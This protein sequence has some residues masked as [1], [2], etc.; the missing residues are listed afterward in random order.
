MEVDEEK[1][2][3]YQSVQNPAS[4]DVVVEVEEA[5]PQPSQHDEK[6][7]S[8][9]LQETSEPPVVQ[10]TQASWQAFAKKESAG[11]EASNDFQVSI[12]Y[13]GSHNIRD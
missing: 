5:K 7:Q 12:Q 3:H 8:N 11:T 2:K 13:N 9:A 1:D 4:S 6:K 10:S